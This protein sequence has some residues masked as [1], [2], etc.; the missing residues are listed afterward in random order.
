MV[1][2][3]SRGAPFKEGRIGR[4]RGQS[5][6][7]LQGGTDKRRRCKQ[8]KEQ[9]EGRAHTTRSHPRRA[10]RRARRILGRADPA[11]GEGGGGLPRRS[12]QGSPARRRRRSRPPQS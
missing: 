9:D 10:D 12:V 1:T 6:H 4:R 5:P 2:K 8:N 3:G 11:R 7:L